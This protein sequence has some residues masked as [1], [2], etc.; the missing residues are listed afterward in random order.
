MAKQ[1]ILSQVIKEKELERKIIS[2]DE[3]D[4]DGKLRSIK[5]IQYIKVRNKLTGMNNRHWWSVI[6]LR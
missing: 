1:N 5:I 6:G 3:K 2:K 4:A